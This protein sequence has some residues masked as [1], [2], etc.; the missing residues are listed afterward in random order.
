MHLWCFKSVRLIW[1]WRTRFTI[2]RW[3]S[4]YLKLKKDE[5]ETKFSSSSVFLSRSRSRNRNRSTKKTLVKLLCAVVVVVGAF[6]FNFNSFFPLHFCCA[7]LFSTHKRSQTHNT[8]ANDYY[9]IERSKQAL[10]VVSL[11]VHPYLLQRSV[12]LLK[13]KIGM[14]TLCAMHVEHCTTA[15]SR[16]ALTWLDLAGLFVLHTQNTK[17]VNCNVMWVSSFH[18]AFFLLSSVARLRFEE[19]KRKILMD[20]LQ[21]L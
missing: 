19:L 11:S 20:I 21:V 15:L 9:Y 7:D 5:K 2:Y 14:C 1:T 4:N 3:P 13:L 12:C 17:M 6:F 16:I 18:F 10:V 8:H